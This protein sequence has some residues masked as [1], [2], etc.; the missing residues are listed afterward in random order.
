MIVAAGVMFTTPD[1][2]VLFLKRADTGEWA[3]P[4]GGIED[5]ETPQQAAM[6]ECRE[7]LGYI[8][9]FLDIEPDDL[10]RPIMLT[11]VPDGSGQF[12]TFKQSTG[13]PFYPTLNH[14][15][16]EALWADPKELPAPIHPGVA[17]VLSVPKEEVRGVAD[18]KNVAGV[19]HSFDEK[20]ET[21][22][23]PTELD[24]ARAIAAGELS[25]PQL[26]PNSA[27]FDLRI[28]GTGAAYRAGLGEYVWR[29]PSIFLSDKFRE[30]CNGLFV[31]WEHP[32][33]EKGQVLDSE[34]FANRIVGA[35]VLPYVRGE[36]L[37]GVSRI[38]DK[39]A[40][41]GLN[42]G[43]LSTS[44]GVV[45]KPGQNEQQRLDGGETVLIEES[46]WL[47]DHLAICGTQNDDPSVG[48]GV[49]DRGGP[50]TGVRVDS[51]EVAMPEILKETNE[52]PKSDAEVT[53]APAAPE[54]A[55]ADLVIAKLDAIAG[56]CDALCK[57]MDAF[58]AKNADPANELNA[59]PIEVAENPVE[60]SRVDSEPE[61]KE[62]EKKEEDVKADAVD[63]KKLHAE[64]ARLQ[65]QITDQN[66][67]IA[68]VAAKVAPRSAS[69]E[70]A[71]ADIQAR[72]DS[73]YMAHGERAK[74]P[75]V[76]EAPAAYRRRVLRD[77]QKWSKTWKDADLASIVDN[78]AFEAIEGQVY[79]D[80]VSAARDPDNLPEEG[81]VQRVHSDPYTGARTITYHGRNTFIMGMKPMARRVLKNA[82]G[83]YFGHAV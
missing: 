66:K 33:P 38:A 53:A 39:N 20:E 45:F 72:A 24:L 7:E 80:A 5:G 83:Q 48:S 9:S 43:L 23:I 41:E 82:K 62:E 25:S 65:G 63:V 49:W 73:V 64:I 42:T 67:T 8:E 22:H 27:L 13:A 10:G 29:D 59:N 15:H 14:E 19:I 79:A 61:K 44:P 4:G 69:D 58:E 34:E 51:T 52:V 77:L 35:V 26:L 18:A 76:G 2:R 11:D 50:P 46:P 31:V 81:L 78:K 57:R 30:R 68:G 36:E 3:F 55:P 71:L 28:T 40:I 54:P 21:K 1:G 75:L 74:P 56:V 6:R 32:P 16:T 47:L 17:Q 60:P 37:R 12:A 70:A